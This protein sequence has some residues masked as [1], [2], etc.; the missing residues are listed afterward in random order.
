MMRKEVLDHLT[1]R[2]P[3]EQR[4]QVLPIFTLG[5]TYG[6]Y[7]KSLQFISNWWI[8]LA[9]GLQYLI[10]VSIIHPVRLINNFDDDML[11]LKILLT[12]LGAVFVILFSQKLPPTRAL[13]FL[14]R[15]TLPMYFMS[16]GFPL[17]ISI[18]FKQYA[19][20]SV[21]ISSLV[22]VLSLAI[23]IMATLLINKYLPFMLDITRLKTMIH[24]N[25]R[26]FMSSRWSCLAIIN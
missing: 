17:V 22:A 1:W 15:N 9:L 25:K 4:L 6:R 5:G 8:V 18:I 3:E 19:T 2:N 24:L 21:W 12:L 11:F 14:G 13:Q 7:E 20:P 16:G 10:L 23:A 26:Y